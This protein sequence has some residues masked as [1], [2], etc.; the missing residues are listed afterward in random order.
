[1]AQPTV[2]YFGQQFAAAGVPAN[3]AAG[4][5]A[6]EG[7][8]TPAQYV[9]DT[10]GQ[11]SVGPLQLNLGGQGSGYT[12]Q[13]LTSNPGLQAQLGVPPIAAAYK[14]AQA[15]GLSG[16][17]AFLYTLTASGHPTEN[18]FSSLTSAEQQTVLQRAMTAWK[19]VT[20]SLPYPF[21]GAPS[22]GAPTS[23]TYIPG[24]GVLAPS[25]ATS[26]PT[27]SLLNTLLGSMGGFNTNET[28]AIGKTVQQAPSQVAQAVGQLPGSISNMGAG[29]AQALQGLT[30]PFANWQKSLTRIAF[31]AGAI[32]VVIAG[33]VIVAL[34]GRQKAVEAVKDAVA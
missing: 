2:P 29:I 33:V 26:G 24:A 31:V 18:G 20:G 12:V 27:P 22:T 34:G 23:T 11:A 19:Q 8:Q 10:N 3:I 14:Q 5:L 1:M 28:A 9:T 30:A 25:Q 15:K 7:S 17:A 4:V 21:G 13:Q 32:V 6:F 16:F